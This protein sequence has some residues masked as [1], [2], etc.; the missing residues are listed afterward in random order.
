[1]QNVQATAGRF[2]P[3]CNKVSGY[4]HCPVHENLSASDSFAGS[5]REA[6]LPKEYKD[7]LSDK[8]RF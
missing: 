4:K 1:L 8:K 3:A 6:R 7:I 2:L 5:A